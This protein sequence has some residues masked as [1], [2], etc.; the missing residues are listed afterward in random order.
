MSEWIFGVHSVVSA[1]KSDAANLSNV[2]IARQSS[3]R[4][5][6]ITQKLKDAGV[7]FQFVERK[8]LDEQFPDSNHQGVAAQFKGVKARNEGGLFDLLSDTQNPLLLILDGVTD[9]HNLGACLRTADGAGVTAVI[10]PRDKAVG[11]TPV[12]RKVACGAAESVPFFQVTNLARTM[13]QLKELGVWIAGTSDKTDQTIY[14][15][16][17]PDSLAIVMGAE[18]T[19]MRRLTTENCDYLIKLPMHG[20]VSSLNVS[21]ATGV[22]LYEMVRR[23]LAS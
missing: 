4:T 15:A 10:A 17:L 5:H 14:D 12:V 22:V 9:P 2:M 7:R 11:I 13:E 18:G 19:G 16:D 20:S 6:E 8:Q 23:R 1:L 3:K 21:V